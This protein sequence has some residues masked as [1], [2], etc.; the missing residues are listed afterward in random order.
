M[1]SSIHSNPVYYSLASLSS[2]QN[3][4]TRTVVLHKRP[5]HS[6]FGVYVGEDVPSG[7]YIVTVERNSPASDANIQPGDRVLAV[8]GQAVS[9]M[10]TNPK[11]AL[12]RAATNAQN[13]TLTIQST[14]IFQTLDI[15]LQNNTNNNTNDNHTHTHYKRKHHSSGQRLNNSTDLER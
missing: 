6:G 7:L 2:R 15:P 10:A 12:I 1:A 8:N 5:E 9:S 3:P 4:S 11:D 13:L 14:N